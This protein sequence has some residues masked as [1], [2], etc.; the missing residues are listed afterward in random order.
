MLLNYRAEQNGPLW[1]TCALL[2][3]A[4]NTLNHVPA[5]KKWIYDTCKKIKHDQSWIFFP[6]NDM[7][8][9]QIVRWPMRKPSLTLQGVSSSYCY[10]E[11]T[12]PFSHR[13]RQ[14]PY[15][16]PMALWHLRPRLLDLVGLI[17]TADHKKQHCQRMS[18]QIQLTLRKSTKYPKILSLD[19]LRPSNPDLSFTW[20]KFFFRS[21][22]LRAKNLALGESRTK[23][24]LDRQ[25]CRKK[26]F[27][28]LREEATLTALKKRP[29]HA[30]ALPSLNTLW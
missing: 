17:K 4:S 15:K 13:E 26:P 25:T 27:T 10:S 8:L 23:H 16:D 29:W 22:D 3:R 2:P 18:S 24:N 11:K 1:P 28:F 21:S 19:G 12:Y 5:K 9:S 14:A 7:F 30:L 6:A 20:H